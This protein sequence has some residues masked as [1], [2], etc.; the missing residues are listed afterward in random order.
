MRHRLLHHRLP[1]FAAVS[2]FLVLVGCS[3]GFGN[4]RESQ[5]GAARATE[6]LV[7]PEHLDLKLKKDALLLPEAFTGETDDDFDQ[8]VA[9][10]ALLAP[11]VLNQIS[12]QKLGDRHWLISPENPSAVWPKLL[13]ALSGHNISVAHTEP[14]IG[15]LETGWFTVTQDDSVKDAL[16]LALARAEEVA[17]DSD[18]ASPE[19]SNPIDTQTKFPALFRIELKVEQAVK[20]GFTEV[21]IRMFTADT[22]HTDELAPEDIHRATSDQ[23]KATMTVL[24]SR[25]ISAPHASVSLMADAI[26]AAPKA[27]LLH[28]EGRPVLRLLL[29]YDRFIATIRKSLTNA[30]LEFQMQEDNGIVQMKLDRKLVNQVKGESLPRHLRG[31]RWHALELHLQWTEEEGASVEVTFEG[32]RPAP[33]WY[34]EQVLILLREYSV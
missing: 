8:V 14:T 26:N 27:E 16:R 31:R 34:A 29:D 6:A 33:P 24:A 23:E 11:E 30:S 3:A 17:A 21:H 13:A 5:Y 2:S 22:Q 7:V 12:V 18:I 20:Q 32:A 4:N 1:L 25:L 15:V 9:P 28:E 19:T 10:V